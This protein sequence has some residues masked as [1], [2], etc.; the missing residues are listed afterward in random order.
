M[1]PERTVPM[2]RASVDQMQRS[3]VALNSIAELRRPKETADFLDSLERDEQAD[4]LDDLLERARFP[5]EADDP[6]YAL[7]ARHRRQLRPYPSRPRSRCRQTF[8]LWSLAVDGRLG[9]AVDGD[10]PVMALARLVVR[11]GWRRGDRAEQ[12]ISASA[13]ARSGSCQMIALIAWLW[14]SARSRK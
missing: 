4:W 8:T 2:V 11:E 6:P 13:H 12:Q 1:F 3:M 9:P 7:C 10:G 5:V 14:H